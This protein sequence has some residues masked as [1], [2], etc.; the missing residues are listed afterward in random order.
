M[1]DFKGINDTWGHL[2]G[3]QALKL[4]SNHLKNI[5]KRAT[6]HIGR[7]GGDEFV[8]LLMDTPKKAV[9]DLVEKLRKEVEL[10][11]YPTE[12]GDVKLTISI[13]VSGRNPGDDYPPDYSV[14]LDEADKALYQAK[15]RGQNQCVLYD[16]SI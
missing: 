1:D 9:L 3:D 12:K 15:K 13:G 16:K 5:F 4:V 14:I 6:D 10:T 11:S 7:F 2:A 8:I